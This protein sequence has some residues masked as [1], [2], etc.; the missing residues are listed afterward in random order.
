MNDLSRRRV[1]GTVG[2]LAG[3]TTLG[4]PVVTPTAA[5]APLHTDQAATTWRGPR[6]ANGWKIL[7]QA[8]THPIEPFQ[9]DGA[10]PRVGQIGETTKLL[11]DGFS[12]KTTRSH[13]EL[14]VLVYPSSGPLQGS[15]QGASRPMP[16]RNQ[17]GRAALDVPPIRCVP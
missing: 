2:T 3:V 11:V 14:L 6:S 15:G 4:L 7:D 12:T 9:P 13:Q 1:L 10:G 17:D 16:M 8:E 5:A